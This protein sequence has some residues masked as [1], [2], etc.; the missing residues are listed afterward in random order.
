MRKKLQMMSRRGP[1]WFE[2]LSDLETNSG[3]FERG[4]IYDPEEGKVLR[5][6][7]EVLSVIAQNKWLDR[8]PRVIGS[9]RPIQGT[10]TRVT[11]SFY[12]LQRRAEVTTQISSA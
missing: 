10:W 6:C 12:A 1:W 3:D 4:K 8:R 9:P 7:H 2:I 11:T 5:R